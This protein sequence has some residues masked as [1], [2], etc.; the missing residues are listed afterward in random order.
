MCPSWKYFLVELWASPL[1]LP[2]SMHLHETNA[3]MIQNTKI[4]WGSMELHGGSCTTTMTLFQKSHG[5]PCTPPCTNQ[6]TKISWG[7]MELPM[8]VQGHHDSVS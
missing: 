3:K 7:S 8:V 4:S 5:A 6:K 2:I 1:C